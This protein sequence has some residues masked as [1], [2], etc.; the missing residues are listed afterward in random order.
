[1]FLSPE[2]V[3][4]FVGLIWWNDDAIILRARGA[5]SMKK[6]FKKSY[7]TMAYTRNGGIERTARIERYID[8]RARS[9]NYINTIHKWD[10]RIQ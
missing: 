6:E 2:W 5:I 1:M 9:L 8:A 4:I 10:R 3:V 7:K